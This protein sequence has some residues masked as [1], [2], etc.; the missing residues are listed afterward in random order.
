MVESCWLA[1]G[2]KQLEQLEAIGWKHLETEMV[3]SGCLLVRCQASLFFCCSAPTWHLWFKVRY[4]LIPEG[5]KEL[6]EKEQIVYKKL[7]FCKVQLPFLQK[8]SCSVGLCLW[9]W[10]WG[11]SHRR[12]NPTNKPIWF[13]L[14]FHLW[15]IPEWEALITI[16]HTLFTYRIFHCNAHHLVFSLK[17]LWKLQLM[18]KKATC[19]LMTRSLA[20]K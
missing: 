17:A 14:V 5:Y 7:Y 13:Q 8:L 10:M 2:W 20:A 19:L 4:C 16:S 18:L 15:P 9:L 1:V 11:Q 6:D 12:N 3:G